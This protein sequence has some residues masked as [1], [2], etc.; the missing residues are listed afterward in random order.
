VTG[1]VFEVEGGKLSIATGWHTGPVRD[2]KARWNPAE[3][4][5]VVAGLIAESPKAQKV[6]GT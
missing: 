6:Y 4:S 1:K 5:D 3:L 2:K